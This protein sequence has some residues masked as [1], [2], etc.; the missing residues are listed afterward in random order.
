M[1]AS[2]PVAAQPDPSGGEHLAVLTPDA[3]LLPGSGVAAGGSD[4][5]PTN[6]VVPTSS[7]NTQ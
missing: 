6:V 5:P 4:V 1:S 7:S 3:D 2:L